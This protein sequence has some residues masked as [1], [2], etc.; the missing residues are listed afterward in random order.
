MGR[1][2]GVLVYGDSSG[3][4]P[5]TTAVPQG[6]ILGPVLPEHF[7]PCLWW[8]TEGALSK[9]AVSTRWEGAVGS[10]EGREALQ[11]ARQPPTHGAW[12]QAVLGSAVGQPALVAQQ[13][14]PW[15]AAKQPR[16]WGPGVWL[17]QILPFSRNNSKKL[18]MYSNGTFVPSSRWISPSVCYINS[19]TALSFLT[20][21][22]WNAY[23]SF[24]FV[25]LLIVYCY[26]QEVYETFC[27]G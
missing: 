7:H 9:P 15:D 8:S 11:R 27:V 18:H 26:Q 3:C 1:A 12:Q 6:S 10:M 4:W 2:H 14:A 5:G 20:E 13:P 19:T 24:G 25:F 17:L 23:L 16:W 21:K 22:F